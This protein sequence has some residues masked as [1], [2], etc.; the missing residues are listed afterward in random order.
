VIEKTT[1]E[2]KKK[3]KYLK[4]K[5]AII[6]NDKWITFLPW[7]HLDEIRNTTNRH[8]ECVADS[9]KHHLK[10]QI[11]K[12]RKEYLM[13]NMMSIQRVGMWEDSTCTHPVIGAGSGCGISTIEYPLVSLRNSANMARTQ[14]EFCQQKT[15][16]NREFIAYCRTDSQ[17]YALTP[18]K[19]DPF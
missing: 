19:G 11:Q 9:I 10:N 6:D 8:G 16:K 18:S 3:A 13:K 15:F 7:C 17:G 1:S 12:E 4:A 5:F 14:N 2:F